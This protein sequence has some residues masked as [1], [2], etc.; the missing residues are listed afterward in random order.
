MAPGPDKH[1]YVI[2]ENG[3]PVYA[4][5]SRPPRDK[6]SRE[7]FEI[8]MDVHSDLLGEHNGKFRFDWTTVKLNDQY[9]VIVKLGRKEIGK[10]SIFKTDCDLESF[11]SD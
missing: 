10:F 1:A 5:H 11:Q 6:E 8:E 7:L 3:I 4:L 2:V 9:S